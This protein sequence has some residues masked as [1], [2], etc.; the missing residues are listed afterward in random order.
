VVFLNAIDK[1]VM[2]KKGQASCPCRFLQI[3]ENRKEL[4]SKFIKLLSNDITYDG[5]ITYML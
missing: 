1:L 3:Q 2:P 4:S 5:L